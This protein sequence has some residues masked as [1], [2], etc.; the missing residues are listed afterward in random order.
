MAS[1]FKPRIF[2]HTSLPAVSCGWIRPSQPGWWWNT[3]SGYKHH[4]WNQIPHC[5]CQIYHFLIP[6]LWGG[7]KMEGYCVVTF[8]GW[9]GSAIWAD[10]RIYT[11]PWVMLDV[12][13]SR[14]GRQCTLQAPCPPAG[15]CV[16][17]HGVQWE[18]SAPSYATCTKSRQG[19]KILYNKTWFCTCGPTEGYGNTAYLTFPNSWGRGPDCLRLPYNYFAGIVTGHEQSQFFFSMPISCQYNFFLCLFQLGAICI[20]LCWRPNYNS[21]IYSLAGDCFS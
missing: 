4:F 17:L 20:W 10:T 5:G 6:W 2:E 7:L 14:V 13:Y 15:C 11:E 21:Y 12:I 19:A 18:V 1:K 3:Q 9:I 8:Q 16:L